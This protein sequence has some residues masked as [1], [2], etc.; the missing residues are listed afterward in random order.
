[1][2][3]FPYFV[4]CRFFRWPLLEGHWFL[5]SSR[6]W[7][8]W[9]TIQKGKFIYL[10]Y[11][12]IFC[13]LCFSTPPLRS[14]LVCIWTFEQKSSGQSRRE[15]LCISQYFTLLRYCQ[16]WKFVLTVCTVYCLYRCLNIWP[17]KPSVLYLWTK[18]PIF[19]YHFVRRLFL[20]HVVNILIMI[21]IS[22]PTALYAVN[23]N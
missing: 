16:K 15:K 10:W 2:T 6:T 9:Q 5:C 1:M 14:A 11:I 8:W 13:C 17:R 22:A 12:Y 7:R 21:F 23:L 19:E 3:K 20:W 4:L 18:I